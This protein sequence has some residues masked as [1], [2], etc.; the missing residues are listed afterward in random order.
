MYQGPRNPRTGVQIYPGF[1]PGSEAS[2]EF[3]G[4]MS[5]AY[6]W[7]LIQGPLA[8]QYAV[9]LLKN[10][11]FGQDWDW[12]TF[13]FDK[14][15][16]KVDAVLHAKIDA[17]NADLRAFQARGGKMIMTQGWGD[18]FNAQTLPIEYREKVIDVFAARD[19]KANAEKIVDGFFRLFMAPGMSHCMGG[20]GPSKFDA[21]AALR[22]WVENGR[23][24]EELVAHKIDIL[25][26]APPKKPMSRLL[27]PYP[28]TARWT[29][30]GS[31]ND[32]SNFICRGPDR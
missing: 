31:T 26:G 18:P 28:Q 8:R 30:K 29:G 7:T 4:R 20:P 3:T 15:V 11:V 32:S 27:C 6:G 17:T 21:L 12:K 9:P 10:M 1:V 19:G 22:E 24:P 16:S 25:S 14:D 13:D 5:M 23:A 2:P